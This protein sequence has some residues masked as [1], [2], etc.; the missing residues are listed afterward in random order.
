MIVSTV[1]KAFFTSHVATRS[2]RK[3]CSCDGTLRQTAS[4][5]FATNGATTRIS[6]S[7]ATVSAAAVIS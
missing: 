5:P 4:S 1:V 3:C 7:S 2:R 6:E